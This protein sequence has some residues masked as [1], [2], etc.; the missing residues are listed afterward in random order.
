MASVNFLYRS[1]KPNA[2]LTVRLLFSYNNTNYVFA[3]K[4]KILVTHEYWNKKHKKK[5]KDIELIN[6]QTE[7]NEQLKALEIYILQSLNGTS[8]DQVN[9]KWFT[10]IIDYYYNPHSTNSIGISEKLSEYISYYI[11]CKRSELTRA[12]IQKFSTIKGKIERMQALSG[13]AILIKDINENFK[14]DF[15]GF[16]TA[17]GYSVNTM[18]KELKIIKTFC[19]HA[20]VNGVEVSI[21]LDSLKIQWQK[22]EKVYLTN[23]EIDQIKQTEMPNKH[24]DNA[25]D[26][27]IIS[28]YTGQRVSDFL[29]FNKDMIRVE[30]GTKLIEFTQKKTNKRM[31]LPLHPEVINILEKNN[32]NFPYSLSDQRYNEYIKEVCRLA[33]IDSKVKGG[34]LN[35]ISRRKQNGMYPK[36]E[37]VTS[38]IGR[39]S[40]ATNFYGIIPTSLLKNATGHS[41]EAMFLEYIGKSQSQQAKELAKYW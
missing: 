39:R 17:N 37:L 19:R 26:W 18:H 29:H 27:L 31:S 24:L 36:Y 10:G 35:S 34:K 7:I 40:F 30:Q 23:K 32:G 4:T 8:I 13:N 21:Q 11:E 14:K 22:P 3:A 25:K 5:Q 9:K 1:S 41:S 20:K 6:K 16:Y 12:S 38:H 15:I 33:G 2:N 28:C